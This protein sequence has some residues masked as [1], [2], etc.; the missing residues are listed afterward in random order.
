MKRLPLTLILLI[1]AAALGGYVWFFER[2]EVGTPPVWKLDTKQIERIEMTSGGKAT[3]I[4]RRGQS[5]RLVKPIEARADR[6]RVK[7]FLDRVGKLEARRSIEEAKRLQDYGL[8]RPAAMLKVVLANGE[9]RELDL[10]D[11]TPDSTAVYAMQKGS[12]KVFLVDTALLEDA[13]GG[14]DALRDRSA[15]PFDRG[16]A[17]RVVIARPKMSVTLEKRGQH[18]QIIA[19]IRTTADATAIDDFLVSLEGIQATRFAAERAQDPAAFGLVSPRLSIEVWASDRG[20]VARLAFGAEADPAGLYAQNSP[21]PAV[22]VVPKSSF[23]RVNKSADDL[24]SKQIASIDVEDAQRIAIMRGGK[25][26]EL[27]REGEEWRLASPR[28]L[29][30]DAQ[31]VEDMLWQL[32]D[33]RAEGFIDGP[34]PPAGYGLEPPQ[35]AVTVY[36]K[37]RKQPSHIWFG[38]PAGPKRIYVKADAPT[39]Y[40]VSAT[41]LSHLPASADDIRNLTLWSYEPADINRLSATYNGSSVALERDGTKWRLTAPEKRPANPERMQKL[42]SMVEAVRAERFVG[43]TPGLLGLNQRTVR[44]T[45]E[46]AARQKR[47][48]LVGAKDGETL[49]KLETEPGVFRAT[50]D[51]LKELTQA[52]DAVAKG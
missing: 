44:L 18:W 49:V 31:K 5:W 23:D 15:L 50:P 40:A 16:K 38:G 51:F 33:L 34:G 52:L 42:L 6:E 20:K 39:I 17:M 7:E 28:A 48:L 27:R 9:S 21:E 32:A 29:E 3:V 30:A 46:T 4:V 11:K 2:G 19:P 47:T 45:I 1:V 43:E 26:F 14:A 35:D 13:A 36:F 25:R 10:G 41:I 37:R 12:A 8:D 22:M 24:R